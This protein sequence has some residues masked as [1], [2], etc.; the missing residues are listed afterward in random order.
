MGVVILPV[1]CLGLCETAAG[2]VLSIHL[3]LKGG[4]SIREQFSGSQLKIFVLGPLH[5]H[6]DVIAWVEGEASYPSGVAIEGVSRNL[7]ASGASLGYKLC[8]MGGLC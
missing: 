4:L 1:T 3:V 7:A 5:A 2:H 6:S 8:S